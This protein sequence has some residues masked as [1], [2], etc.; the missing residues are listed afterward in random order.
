MTSLFDPNYVTA[1]LGS[2]VR[3][4]TRLVILAKTERSFGRHSQVTLESELPPA[5]DLSAASSKWRIIIG[6]GRDKRVLREIDAEKE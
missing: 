6:N 4:D 2:I 1:P 5:S 3:T